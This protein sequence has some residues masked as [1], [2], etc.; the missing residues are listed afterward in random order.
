MSGSGTSSP[1]NFGRLRGLR[2]AK[3][4][5][6]GGGEDNPRVDFEVPPEW[7]P[8]LRTI[9]ENIRRHVNPPAALGSGNRGLAGKASAEIYK[10]SLQEPFDRNLSAHARTYASFTSDMGVELGLPDFVVPEDGV[11]KLLPTWVHR[12]TL[13]PDV[14]GQDQPAQVFGRTR[15]GAKCVPKGRGGELSEL[16]PD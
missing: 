16:V 1:W 13:G 10:W 11:E 15:Q 7:L 12:H 9:R 8:W 2:E 3:G 5:A 4:A 14:G 6:G